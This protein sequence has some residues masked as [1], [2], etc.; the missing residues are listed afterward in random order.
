M[1]W[2]WIFSAPDGSPIAPAG[3]ADEQS[4]PS[5]SDAETWLGEEWRD[6][7]AAGVSSVTL[8]E[9]EREVYGPMPLEAG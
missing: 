3:V 4:F 7:A 5:Q 9:A 8:R 1:T 6:L 2:S